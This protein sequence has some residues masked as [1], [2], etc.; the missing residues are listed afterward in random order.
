MHRQFF[1]A[2]LLFSALSCGGDL[3]SES[4]P[5]AEGFHLLDAM[6]QIDIPYKEI[7]PNFR[8]RGAFESNASAAE[9]ILTWADDPTFAEFV[10]GD[11]FYSDA[12]SFFALRDKM[13]AGAQT[14]LDGAAE[15]DVDVMREGFIM[16]KQ[17]CIG[18]HKRF[19]PSY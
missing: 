4:D 3:D 10:E 15:T 9:E 13:K 2:L 7:E 12:E 17:S 19:S 18:C 14:V 11:R 16:L 5:E 6:L 1:S 8:N